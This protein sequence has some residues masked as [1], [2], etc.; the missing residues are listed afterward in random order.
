MG[1]KSGSGGTNKERAAA[2]RQRDW[3]GMSRKHKVALSAMQ[4]VISKDLACKSLG[5]T[6]NHLHTSRPS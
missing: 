2:Y 1:R 3:R 4:K 6:Q 5:Q